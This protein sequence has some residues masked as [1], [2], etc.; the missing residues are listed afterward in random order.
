M[1]DNARPGS[2]G[3]RLPASWM[4]N[5]PTDDHISKA[6]KSIG[7]TVKKFALSGAAPAAQFVLEASASAFIGQVF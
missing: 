5:A 7:K 3:R 6:A 2:I 1:D 4:L